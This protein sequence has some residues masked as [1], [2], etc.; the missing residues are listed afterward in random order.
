MS[1][2][3]QNPDSLGEQLKATFDSNNSDK[4]YNLLKAG[5][6]SIP[7][8]GSLVL[9]LVE[10][11]IVS[12]A[13]KRLHKFLETLV[14]ELEE[15]KLKIDLVDFDSP[16]F[17]TTLIHTCQIVIRTHQEQK[18]EALRNIVLN[19]AIP[20]ALED[21]ILAMFLNWIDV[22]TERH[23]STLKHLHYMETY[24]LQELQAHFPL[25]EKNKFIYNKVLADLA[26]Q[27]LINLKEHYI[28]MEDN[29]NMSPT[30]RM[31]MADIP[32]DMYIQHR[33]PREIKRKRYK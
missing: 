24:T 29:D 11:Y 9:G 31:M 26:D 28:T 12:P 10:S 6:G 21:D 4:N 17:Q 25:L 14:R 27:G 1:N 3:L 33:H 13:T 16:A 8:V 19:S 30:V 15:L 23:I 5:I 7:S 22:F 18:L 2:D 20:R 32:L